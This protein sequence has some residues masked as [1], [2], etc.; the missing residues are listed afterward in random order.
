M[1]PIW[2]L[3]SRWGASRAY[4]QRILDW[5]EMANDHLGGQPFVLSCCTLCASAGKAIYSGCA[6]GIEAVR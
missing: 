1:L 5:H 6:A 3:E 4:P 2:S